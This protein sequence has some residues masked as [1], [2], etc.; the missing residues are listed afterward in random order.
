MADLGAT[1][2]KADSPAGDETRDWAPPEY[3]G[4]STYYLGIN[5]NKLEIVLDLNDAPDRAAAQEL[6]LSRRDRGHWP[7]PA[8]GS[9]RPRRHGRLG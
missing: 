6:P 5:G 9:G 4:V 7:L 8:H 1:V 3:T 2:I